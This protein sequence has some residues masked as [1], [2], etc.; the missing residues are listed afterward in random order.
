PAARPGQL[1]RLR[2]VGMAPGRAV[3]MVVVMMIMAMVVVMMRVI[4][5]IVTVAMIVVIMMLVIVRRGNRSANGMQRP[6]QV[7]RLAEKAL[8][9]D[10]D[11]PRADERDQSIACKLDDPLGAAHLARGGIEQHR[12]DADDRNRNEGLQ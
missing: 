2:A 11:E 8:A 1:F 7:P 4:V 12:R 10:P 9:L 5:V 6:A 3:V